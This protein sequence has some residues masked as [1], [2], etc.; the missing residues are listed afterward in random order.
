[1]PQRFLLTSIVIILLLI[2]PAALASTPTPAGGACAPATPCADGTTAGAGLQ[3]GSLA[4]ESVAPVVDVAAQ[5][6]T[7]E[8][9]GLAWAVMVLLVLALLYAIL[10]AVLATLGRAF[11]ALPAGAQIAVPILSVLGLAVALYLSYIET[12]STAAV[13]GPVGD[14]NAVQASPFAMLFGFLP[15]GVLGAVGYVGILAAWFIG[16]RSHGSL[17]RLAPLLVFGMALFGVL[18]TIYLT[19]LEIFVIKAVCIWCLTSAVIM[20]L[21]LALSVAPALEA[22]QSDED[23]EE[24]LRTG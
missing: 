3:L 18:F 5:E 12:T 1:M 7:N 2:T 15:V 19:Y 10:A 16:R 9:F 8:G 13:C 6:V 21:V 4:V 20:A 11:P 14:C 23:P 22:L 24:A 17:G